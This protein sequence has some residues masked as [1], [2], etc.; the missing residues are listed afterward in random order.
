MQY[1]TLS[2][3]GSFYKGNLH[4]HTTLSDG[5][6]SPEDTIQKYM[7]NNYAF[8]SITDHNIYG[9]YSD[10]NTESFL[11]IPGIEFDT[12]NTSSESKRHHIVGIGHPGDTGFFH[13]ERFVDKKSLRNEHVQDIINFLV[14]KNNLAIYAHP[15]WSKVDISDIVYLE[16]LTGMEIINYGC[17]ASWRSGNA[18]VFFEHFL[19]Q[20][21][22]IWCMGT[23]DSHGVVNDYFGGYIVVKTM[24]FSH[25]GIL[26]A[27]RNGSFYACYAC[28]GKEAPAI[29][30][31]I[32]EDGIAKIACQPCRV[33][34]IYTPIGHMAFHGTE[35]SPVTYA[36]YKI[37]PECRYVKATCVGFGGNISWAQPILI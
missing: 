33:V 6:L 10:W 32:V 1:Y 29:I 26:D 5:V 13:G 19:W 24:D 36:E 23:D 28:D 8:L 15:Y 16:N 7:K 22:Y 14:A 35:D 18:E 34:Y 30:D 3:N 31:F 11:M 12:F 37:K 2:R 4:T 27:I 21:N 20:G 17:E 9:I 25:R